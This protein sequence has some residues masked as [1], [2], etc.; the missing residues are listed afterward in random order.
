MLE[1]FL[2]DEVEVFKKVKIHSESNLYTLKYLI[3]F[4]VRQP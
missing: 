1:L 4:T 3:L 2:T